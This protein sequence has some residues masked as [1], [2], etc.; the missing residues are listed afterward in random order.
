[1]TKEFDA[2]SVGICAMSVCSSLPVEEIVDRAN[3]EY[4]TGISSRWGLSEATEFHSGQP[5]PCP[6]EENPETHKHY[7]LV[8]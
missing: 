4:P 1:M 8:C 2:Y 3:L 6:C 7:L 5:N